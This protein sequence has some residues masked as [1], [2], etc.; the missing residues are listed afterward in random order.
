MHQCWILT[1]LFFL[2]ETS[3]TPTA[4]LPTAARPCP[5][6]WPW[7]TTN[8]SSLAESKRCPGLLWGAGWCRQ[9][10]LVFLG[11]CLSV[12]TGEL[13]WLGVTLLSL[14]VVL[15]CG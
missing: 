12:E 6:R 2:Q 9:R 1:S 13:P 10:P 8:S 3:S 15:P 7:S 4:R 11:L 14:Q 5:V